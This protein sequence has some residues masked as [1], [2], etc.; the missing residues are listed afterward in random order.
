MIYNDDDEP[1][2]STNILVAAHKINKSLISV[3]KD[4]F[5]KQHIQ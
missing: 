4:I 3:R 2:F 5:Y 1:S